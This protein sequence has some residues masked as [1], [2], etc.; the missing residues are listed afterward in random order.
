MEGDRNAKR[1]RE[2]RR[3]HGDF[4]D[5]KIYADIICINFDLNVN[6]V[7]SGHLLLAKEDIIHTQYSLFIPNIQSFNCYVVFVNQY[8]VQNRNNY[9]ALRMDTRYHMFRGNKQLDQRMDINNYELKTR[10][11]YN[12]LMLL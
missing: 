11:E 2:L 7:Y 6:N 1:N 12:Y 5:S 9:Y 4:E 8:H 10:F 3:Q